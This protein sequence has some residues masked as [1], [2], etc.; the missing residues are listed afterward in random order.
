M[1]EN[2][3]IYLGDCLEVMKDIDNNSIDL[4]L[5]DPPYKIIAGGI[6]L[7]DNGNECSGVLGR[8]VSD[9]PTYVK[10]GKMFTHNDIK[11]AE[12]LP[13]VFRVLK[14]G[15][16]CYIMTN[17][18]NIQELLN[19]ATK[20]GFKLLNIL[21]WSKNNATPNKYYMKSAEFILFFRKGF[22]K[23]I[24]DM[25]TKT[26]LNVNNIIGNKVHPSE[27]P[28]D[29]LKILIENSSKEGEIV[30]DCFAGSGNTCK[31]SKEL[32][33]NFIGIEIDPIYYEISARSVQ[34]QYESDK[35]VSI[36]ELF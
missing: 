34:D 3:K 11:F 30:L 25:G 21:V 13:D 17:D 1:L 26:V 33:R 18:R 24:N 7:K 12:W 2:N 23:S 6:S 31:T 27:K 10:Q 14:D 19:E 8:Y 32:K 16:H 35:S 22:A 9:V 36:D 4:F 15:S 28:I 29:L 5:T 20:V